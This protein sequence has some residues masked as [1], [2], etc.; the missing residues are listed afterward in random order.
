MSSATVLP[1]PVLP[2]E[3]KCVLADVFEPGF[4]ELMQMVPGNPF[5]RAL[6]LKLTGKMPGPECSTFEQLK[7][8][9]EWNCTKGTRPLSG[10]S[11][12]RGVDDRGISVGVD[13]SETECGR[14]DYSVRRHGREEFHVTADSLLEI[15]QEAI[16]TGGG[17]EEVIDTVA[18]KI[19]DDAWT[20]CDPNLGDYG[21]Y[22]YD[23]HD[24]TGTS[25]SETSYSRS[26][27]RN[28]VLA[29]MRARYPELAAEL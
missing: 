11:R 3:R 21:D 22:N 17:M 28:A 23:E 13:F 19:D 27:I 10:R 16:E 24:S 6:I 7:D 5:V 15:I 2:P 4:V 8:W 18:G 14:A 29:F 20:Q 9:I 1:N 26:E 25:D 12:G